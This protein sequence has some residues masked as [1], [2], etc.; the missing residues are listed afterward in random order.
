MP[1]PGPPSPPL[2]ASLFNSLIASRARADRVADAVALLARMLAAGVAP[3]AFTFAPILSAPSLDARYAAQLHA[4]VL[5]GGM[6]HGEPYTATALL[7]F[8]GRSGRFDDALKV[9]A[10]TAVRS[11]VTWNC[12][13]ASL[14]R[15]GRAH[16]AVFWFRELVTSGDELSDVS[17]VAVLPAFGSPEQVHGLVKKI[18]M[19]S[20]AAVANS[21]LNS[22]CSCSSL[23]MAEKLFDEF[24]V[25]DVVSW[26]TMIS[27]FARSCVPERAFEIFLDMQ[28]HGVFPSETTFSS[29]LYACTSMNGHEHGKSIHAKAIKQSLNTS[30]FVSTALVDFYANCVGRSDAHKVFQ[31]VPENSTSC[32]NALISAHSDSDDPTSLVI[33]RDMLRSGIQPNEV[34]FSSSLKDPSLLDLRQIHSLV[35]RLGHGD[36]DYVSSAI[37]SSYASHGILSDALAYGVS[38]DPDSCSISMN[39][40]AGIYN[41]SHMYQ[42]T[43]E[44]LL[45]Q[46][47]SDT[48][49]W[50][51]LITACARN[52]DYVEAFGFFKQM[53]ILGHRFD[54]YIFVSLLTI[55]TKNNSLDLGKLIHG[56]IIKTNSGS[57]DT[58]VNNMLLDMYAKC[59]RIEDC[60]KVFEEMEDRNLISWTAVISGLGLNGFAHKALAWFEA[61]EKD[62]FRPDKVAIL[63]VLSA[64]R[65]GRLVQQG[66]KI[67]KNMRA[68]YSV[69]AEMEHYI[70][71]VDMLC[72]CGQLKEAE[73]VIRDMPFRPS[74]VIWRTFLQGCKTYGIMEAQ[75]F[76]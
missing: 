51:I 33:L 46:K 24:I 11:V 44:L 45:H 6:L 16:D 3:T 75:V 63:A 10:E 9:F 72:K 15:F 36:N 68:D 62:G 4:R 13:I 59:G 70:C 76:S 22:Y 1:R 50:S 2:S 47:N 32:W 43:K 5:K 7:G 65:H 41:R 54:K 48:V 49:S 55:C 38:L 61:M 60:L 39:V 69:K 12:L 66:M 26:N 25:R 20:F 29:V 18:G 42:E 31:E 64:C 8:F 23:H 21:L 67:F 37:I 56:L 73:V 17:L 58:Y 71:V 74:T 30:V 34:S 27:S 19:D 28:R 14:V 35:T 40:L 52:G 57:S 53:R